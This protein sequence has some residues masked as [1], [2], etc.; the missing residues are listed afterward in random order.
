L[1]ANTGYVGI[2]K[3]HANTD[4]PKKKSKKQPLTKQDKADNRTISSSR[5][6]VEN[7]IRCLKIFRIL[8][9][10]YRNR[11]KRYS[12]R[13]NLIAEVYNFLWKEVYLVNERIIFF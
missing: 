3:L 9:E 7:V 2:L 12:L 13:L 8:A 4:I 11:R 10:K 5:V 6:L 1:Q